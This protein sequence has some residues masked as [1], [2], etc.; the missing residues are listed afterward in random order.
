[1]KISQREAHKLRKRVVELE[2]ILSRQKNAWVSEW[3]P[4]WTHI[5]TI[6]LSEVDSAKLK[7]ARFLKHAVVIVPNSG[8]S[9]LLYAVKL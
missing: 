2:N 9:G 7:T 6:E 4:G 8:N 5:T 1:M 3:V